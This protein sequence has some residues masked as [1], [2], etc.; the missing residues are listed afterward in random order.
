MVHVRTAWRINVSRV[1]HA[2]ADGSSLV[3]TVATNVQSACFQHMPWDTLVC[4][5]GYGSTA[6]VGARICSNL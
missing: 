2:T 6:V 1:P 4:L 3:C 5:H